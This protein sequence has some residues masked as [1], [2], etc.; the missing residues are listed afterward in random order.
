MQG[1][2]LNELP[3]GAK[4]KVI[5]IADSDLGAKLS[6]MGLIEGKEVRIL[7]R[8]PLG[9]PLAIDMGGHVLSLRKSE[10][11]LVLVLPI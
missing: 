4:I 7:Y 11:S 3:N 6:E 9:C 10:A 5:S 8:A 1:Q 2:G